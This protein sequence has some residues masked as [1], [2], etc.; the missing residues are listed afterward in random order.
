[1]SF[2][3]EGNLQKLSKKVLII[4]SWATDAYY[5]NGLCN[6]LYIYI[7]F[8]I[9]FCAMVEYF[10]WIHALLTLSICHPNKQEGRS[11]DCSAKPPFS[12]L[13]L[14]DC[15]PSL[16][17]RLIGTGPPFWHDPNCHGILLWF[18]TCAVT[19]DEL[20]CEASMLPTTPTAHVGSLTKTYFMYFMVQIIWGWESGVH[21][22]W[23]IINLQREF[24]T[25]LPR[26]NH[27][28]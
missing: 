9:K 2:R 7:F 10:E 21:W 26:M 16:S 3:W 22:I 12:R 18:W 19:R 11:L 14:P 1:M 25:F 8:W 28:L 15:K 5:N 6:Y 24:L 27:L 13:R 20:A 17:S 4:K 23:T